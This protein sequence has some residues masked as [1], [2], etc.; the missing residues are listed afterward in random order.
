MINNENF[1]DMIDA[2]KESDTWSQTL[3]EQVGEIAAA[4]FCFGSD[5]LFDLIKDSMRDIIDYPNG[6]TLS[7]INDVGFANALSDMLPKQFASC[8][9]LSF[10]VQM[11]GV[12]ENLRASIPRAKGRV[13]AHTVMEEIILYLIMG[14]SED[15]GGVYDLYSSNDNHEFGNEKNEDCMQDENFDHVLETWAFD[16]FDDA[17][18]VTYLYS[19][20]KLPEKHVYHFSRWMEPQFYTQT[21]DKK[22]DITEDSI[23]ELVLGETKVGETTV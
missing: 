18:V 17:D 14:I 11:K 2:M 10:L 20:I 19:D 22:C 15:I 7:D 4:S 5:L 23:R 21:N 3:A 13:C 16:V 1:S 12:L 6:T 8:Y 9:N